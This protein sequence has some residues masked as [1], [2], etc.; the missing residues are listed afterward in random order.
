MYSEKGRTAVLFQ[1]QH[2]SGRIEQNVKKITKGCKIFVKT[3]VLSHV[4]C[5]GILTG[6]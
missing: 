4:N 2:F 6:E 1:L 5:G 3:S